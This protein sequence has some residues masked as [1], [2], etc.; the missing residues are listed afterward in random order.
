MLGCDHIDEKPQ[1]N[2][3]APTHFTIFVNT[4]NHIEYQCVLW[5]HK[6]N[7]QSRFSF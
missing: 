7:A 2:K 6:G 1:T 4:G 3:K 5:R